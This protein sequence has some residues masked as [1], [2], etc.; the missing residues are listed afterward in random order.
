MA[1][2]WIAAALPPLST[3]AP[4]PT[5]SSLGHACKRTLNGYRRGDACMRARAPFKRSRPALL[6]RRSPADLG[7]PSE[8]TPSGRLFPQR[9]SVQGTPRPQVPLC[10]TASPQAQPGSSSLLTRPQV[11]FCSVTSHRKPPSA[12]SQDS[13][14][15]ADVDE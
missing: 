10:S 9:P 12:T 2:F 7:V 8:G 15:A 11:S 3:V 5:A 1:T 14:D 6:K 4:R 13:T